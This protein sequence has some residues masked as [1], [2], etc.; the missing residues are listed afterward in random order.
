VLALH[1][2]NRALNLDPVARGMAG[3]L[4]FAARQIISGDEPETG[5]TSSRWV[6]MS[7]SQA[8][9]ER[10]GLEHHLSGWSRRAPILWTDDFSSLWP[11]LKF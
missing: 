3:Y 2:S 11:V 4:G 6:L 9:L 7:S 1:I 5:E 10:A 8:F